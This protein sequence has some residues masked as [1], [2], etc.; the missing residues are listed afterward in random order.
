MRINVLDLGF[1]PI[2]NNFITENEN[3]FFYRCNVSFDTESYH[4]GLT[5]PVK[6]DMLFNSNYV[7]H[8][9]NSKPMVQYF[10]NLSKEIENIL[11]PRSVLEIGSNDGC[12]IKNWPTDSSL[13]VEPSSNLSK[14][15]NELGYET[16]NDFFTEK[17]SHKIT[18]NH[19]KFDLI[20][21]ANCICHIPDLDDV[22]KGIKNLLSD[23]GI[24]IF[25]D[26]SLL[27]MIENN[28]YDQIYDEH[29]HIFSIIFLEKL[30][31]KHEL[32]IVKVENLESH[33]GSNRVWVT[34]KN[35]IYEDDSVERELFKEIDAGLNKLETY[36]D[37]GVRVGESKRKLINILLNLKSEGKR[38]LSYGATSK[39]TTIFN[40]CGITDQL[41][42][43]ISDTSKT[44]IG[45][46]SPGVNLKVVDRNNIN[47]DDYDYIFLGAWN[48]KDF[49]VE[50]ENE[51]IKN[52]GKI[53]THVPNVEIL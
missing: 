48:F 38:V 53:I 9:S 28:S 40:Y 44:K 41:I 21:S 31:D 50:K 24:F 23:N 51:W 13:C 2:A 22:F 5:K 4:F 33:G 35:H 29:P 20:Y 7:Y 15:T 8:T 49:I 3:E 52:G 11:E 17:L 16:Y 25:E 27:K 32:K 45:K 12:F 14:I 39:S 19:G 6:S 46:L 18:K 43:C 34:H 30:V 10:K 36:I 37:F 42:D 26:P 47:L 1:Q